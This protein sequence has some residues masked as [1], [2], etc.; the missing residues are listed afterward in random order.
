MAAKAGVIGLTRALARELGEAGIPVN[1]VAPG[2]TLTERSKRL[3]DEQA[4]AEVLR[5][6]TLMRPGAPEDPA[7]AVMFLASSESDFMTGQTLCVDGGW[8]AR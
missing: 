7:G 2:Y 5:R 1:A 6:Q 8:V 3:M 4:L